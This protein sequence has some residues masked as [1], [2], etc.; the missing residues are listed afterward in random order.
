MLCNLANTSTGG[1]DTNNNANTNSSMEDDDSYPLPTIYRCR[2]PIASLDCMEEFNGGGGGAETGVHCSN[3]AG[4]KEQLLTSCIAAQAQRLQHPSPGIRYR[5][6]GKSGLRVSNVGLGTWT[7]FGVGG[8]GNEETAEAVVALAYDSGINVFDLSEA[9]S[10]HRA[11]I[12]F[13]RILLRRAWNRS[14]YV[15]TT[16]IYWNTKTEGRGLSRKHIIESVQASLV[17]LQLSYID[18]VM[19]HKVDPMCPMEGKL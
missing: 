13:G 16:K 19:I 5:N 2:A 11:E 9:H 7:T 3:T 12:Q 10:G 6:L 4:T 15:V 17:R 8:C 1:N 14:S 18:I